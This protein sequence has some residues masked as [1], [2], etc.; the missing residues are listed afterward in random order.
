MLAIADI[1]VPRTAI[2]I[3]PSGERVQSLTSTQ[4]FGVRS[5]EGIEVL[6]EFNLSG[7]HS[8]IFAYMIASDLWG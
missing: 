8:L 3:H 4:K 5:P 2:L 7:R 1:A 6:T